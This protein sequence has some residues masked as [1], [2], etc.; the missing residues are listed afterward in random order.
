MTDPHA[1]AERL[2]RRL[3]AVADPSVRVG[4]LR[5]VVGEME[6]GT[7]ADVLTIAVHGAE[8]RDGDLGALLL[9]LCLALADEEVAPLRDEIVRAALAR[10]QHATA[11]LLQPRAPERRAEEPLV[12]PDFGRGR[13]VTLG[14]RKALA[15][16][17]DRDL[18]ARV[19]RDPHPD[20]IRVVL[21]NPT[22]TERDVIRV[23]ARRPIAPEVLREVFRS[24]RW[25]VRYGVK[26]AIVRNPF[27][28]VDLALQLAAHL[29]A[30]DAREAARCAELAVAVRDACRRV[31]GIATLH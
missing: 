27:A 3:V 29:N 19:L 1:L 17:R 28:P 14:E 9:A 21:G 23:C 8:A 10:G 26:K 22:I 11:A 13:A 25:I 7:V 24:P 20:V 5:H 15:R 16:T 2:A 31:A 6:P 4:Y 12:V 18:L 30:A